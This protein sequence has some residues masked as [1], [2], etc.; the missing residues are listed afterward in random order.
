MKVVKSTLAAHW[1]HWDDPGDYPNALASGAQ[2]DREFIN[3]MDG[4]AV[5]KLSAAEFYEFIEAGE[6]GPSELLWWLNE[7]A[8]K[9]NILPPEIGVVLR[10]QCQVEPTIVPDDAV[11]S[12]LLK[13]SVEHA[14]DVVVQEYAR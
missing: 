12:W 7:L 9:L 8:E 13:L 2:P 5:V 1:E 10:W 11:A 14:D 6:A 4:Q 3:G